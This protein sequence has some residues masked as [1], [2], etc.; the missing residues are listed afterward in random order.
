MAH[1]FAFYFTKYQK[2]WT[3][4]NFTCRIKHEQSLG[5]LP[6]CCHF[7]SV[8][9]GALGLSIPSSLICTSLRGPPHVSQWFGFPSPSPVSSSIDAQVFKIKRKVYQMISLFANQSR[10]ETTHFWSVLKFSDIAASPPTPQCV[11]AG[12]ELRFSSSV[13]P[14]FWFW[15][16]QCYATVS[17]DLGKK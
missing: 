6:T 2:N 16:N 15:S 1:Y 8:E 17:S 5:Q 7:F 3:L 10:I 4:I 13:G 12:L 11:S 9:Q 14:V